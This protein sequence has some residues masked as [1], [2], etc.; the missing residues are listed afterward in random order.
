MIEKR[1][2]IPA[3]PGYDIVEGVIDEAG[4]I[5][6][7]AYTP[8]VAWVVLEG[9]AS[10]SA[11]PVGLGLREQPGA[12]TFVRTPKGHFYTL[13]GDL[14]ETEQSVLEEMQKQGA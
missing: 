5:V 13:N 11:W 6:D 12:G 4:N 7:L 3:Q 10:V 8:V 9:R 14:F 1:E 2:V